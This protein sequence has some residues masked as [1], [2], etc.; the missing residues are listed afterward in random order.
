MDVFVYGT[1]TDPETVAEV[2][3]SYAFVGGAVLE[4]LHPVTGQY[5][6]LAPGGETGGRLLRTDEVAELDAYEGLDDGIYVRVVV[7]K[8]DADGEPRGEVA[9][10]VGNH[11]RL[12]VVED[13]TWP[14]E[15]SLR[16]R[17]A[18]YVD[19]EG[20]RVRERRT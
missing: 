17:V 18:A 13:V 7:P 5:P 15:G 16:E 2:V 3:D 10:Y 12:G 8:V 19:A 20:V 14:G 1:L 11:E 6:S 9:V 4:G